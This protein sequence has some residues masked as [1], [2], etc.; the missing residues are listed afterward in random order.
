VKSKTL[1]KGRD[2]FYR[3]DL[4]LKYNLKFSNVYILIVQQCQLLIDLLNDDGTH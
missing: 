2:K 1:G 3:V 4:H